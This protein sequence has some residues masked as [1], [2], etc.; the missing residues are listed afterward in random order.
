MA[1]ATHGALVEGRDGQS[2]G[3]AY[4]DLLMTSYRSSTQSYLIHVTHV[5][6]KAAAIL[7]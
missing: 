1:E 2:L 4:R 7:K 3:V 6:E 5:Y